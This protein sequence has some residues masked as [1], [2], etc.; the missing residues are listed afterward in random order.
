VILEYRKYRFKWWLAKYIT[1]KY[2]VHVDLELSSA[3]NLKCI[4][5]PHGEK[6]QDFK[7]CFMSFNMVQNIVNEIEGKVPS[8]KLQ[9]RG[10]STLH[11]DFVDILEHVRGKF[12]DSRLNTNGN[13]D[14]SL[15][16]HMASCL[17]EICFSVDAANLDTYNKIR[18]KGKFGLVESNIYHLYSLV[19]FREWGRTLKRKPVIK[20]SF[21]MT[22]E[23]KDQVKAF[24]KKWR[25]LCPKI[26]FFIR[27]AAQRTNDGEYLTDNS[28]AV[29]RKDCHMPSRRLVITS[30]GK[31]AG[32]C[33][34]WNESSTV[35]AGDLKNKKLLDIWSVPGIKSLRHNLKHWNEKKLPEMCINC[36][37]RESY[38]WKAKK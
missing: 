10:E 9:L 26:K 29:G 31:V 8:I 15:N 22:K 3:C 27:E 32:C 38:Q 21:V 18:I 7:K 16:K 5:C 19:H 20:L 4:F 37:S 30:T 28:V 1:P 23:N 6:K 11:P 12:I 17:T 34:I 24:K 36:Y 33:L 35:F 14:Q 2:P 13:Y 25:K